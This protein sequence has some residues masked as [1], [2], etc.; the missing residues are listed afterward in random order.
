[1]NFLMAFFGGVLLCYAFLITVRHLK[2]KTGL[3]LKEYKRLPFLSRVK[4]ILRHIVYEFG[5]KRNN[6]DFLLNIEK[7]NRVII[8]VIHRAHFPFLLQDKTDEIN[9]GLALYIPIAQLTEIEKMKI[10]KIIVEEQVSFQKEDRPFN[11]FVV[12]IG[13]SIRFGAYLISKLLREVYNFELNEGDFNFKLFNEG[14]LSY[15]RKEFESK[16][17]YN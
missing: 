1:M 16:N 17:L 4:D 15:F 8:Q 6:F 12:D 5:V 2:Q 11:Y 14:G 7:D 3:N 10:E 13:K 9:F